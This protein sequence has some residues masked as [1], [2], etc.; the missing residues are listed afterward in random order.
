MD[1]TYSILFL[2]IWP[3]IK[4]AIPVRIARKRLLFLGGKHLLFEVQK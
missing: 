1:A 4:S 2:A 3:K